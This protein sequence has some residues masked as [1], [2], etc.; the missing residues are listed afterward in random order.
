MLPFFGISAI[1]VATLAAPSNPVQSGVAAAPDAPIVAAA[2]AQRNSD[3][4]AVTVQRPST[5]TQDDRAERIERYEQMH[6]IFPPGNGG[7]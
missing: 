2:P 6:L 1:V 5:P 3:Q 7:G 4:H